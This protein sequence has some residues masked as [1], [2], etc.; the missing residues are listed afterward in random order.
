MSNAVTNSSYYPGYQAGERIKLI[1]ENQAL[2]NANI[3]A[4]VEKE[5]YDQ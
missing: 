2:L 3:K 5:I 1:D 4:I